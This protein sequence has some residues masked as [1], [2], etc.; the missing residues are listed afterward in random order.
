MTPQAASGTAVPLSDLRA[1]LEA[2]LPRLLDYWETKRG[3]RAMPSWAGMDPLDFSYMLGRVSLVE[4]HHG[5]PMRF[6]YRV[7][8]TTL[9]LQLGYEMTGRFTDDIP[10]AQVR[11]YVE[12]QYRQLVEARVP[13][14]DGGERVLDGRRWNHQCLYLPLSSDGESVDRLLAGRIVSQVATPH[15]SPLDWTLR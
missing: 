11:A 8:A 13:L 4:V 6:R 15:E 5:T 12:A 1:P 9:S 7:V 3:G 14:V 10:E 2:P